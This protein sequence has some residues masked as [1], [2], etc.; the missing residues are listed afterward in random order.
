M[1]TL[2]KAMSELKELF[3]KADVQGEPIVSISFSEKYDRFRFQT[4]L[5]NDLSSLQLCVLKQ[6]GEFEE[7]TINGI[8]VRI[9]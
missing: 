9:V 6:I 8:K 1:S 7:I 5:R 4:E 3:D 2:I